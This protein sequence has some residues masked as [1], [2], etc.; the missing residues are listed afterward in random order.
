[1]IEE[2]FLPEVFLLEDGEVD[3]DAAA[4]E[5]ETEDEDPAVEG[6]E[7]DADAI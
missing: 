3:P 6:T 5:E 4:D 1:M 2:Q 7:G